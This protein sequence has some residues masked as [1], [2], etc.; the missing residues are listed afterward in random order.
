MIKVDLIMSSSFFDYESY[1]PHGMCY[2]WKGEILWTSVISDVTT[3]LAYY[4]ITIAFIVFVKKRKDLAY[5]WFFI[6]AGS[7]I[8]MACGTSHIISA[9]VVWEP[10]YG[11]SAV[12]KAITA[13][14]SLAAGVL[15]WYILPF[16]ISLPSPSMLE[17]IVKKRTEE[18]AKSNELLNEEIHLHKKSCVQLENLKNYMHNI[19]DSM[20]SILIG[21]DRN[22]LITQWN[23]VA[24]EATGLSSEEA[25]GM[26]LAEAFPRLSSDTDTVAT[27]IKTKQKQVDIKRAFMDSDNSRYEDITIYPLMSNGAE[28]AVIRID[29]VTEQVI[30]EEQINRTQ[31]MDVFGKLAGGVAHDFNNMLGIVIGYADLLNSKMRLEPKLNKYVDSIHKAAI[32]GTKLTNKLMSFSRT[33]SLESKKTNINSIIVEQLDMIQKALTV[34]INLVLA[35]DEKLWSTC[36]DQNELV[37]AVLN[38][39]INAMHAMSNKTSGAQLTITTKNQKLNEF[40]IVNIG[41]KNVGDYIVL[42]ITDNGEGMDNSAKEKLFDPF[43]STKGDKGTGLGLFQVFGFINRCGGIIKVYSEIDHGSKFSLYFPRSTKEGTGNTII[44]RE[45]DF[46]NFEQQTI[47]VVDDEEDLCDLMAEMLTEQGIKVLTTNNADDALTLLESE[48]VDLLISDIIMPGTDGYQL[49][50]IVSDKY[51]N[52][53][54]QLVSGFSDE[55]HQNLV[56][57]SIQENILSKPYN[58]DDLLRSI[59]RLLSS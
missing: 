42:S 28:G 25:T 48:N 56:D 10:I 6:L 20:P 39:C 17:D 19:I 31:K 37:D 24:C 35:L 7:I 43:F 21:V 12:A 4:S 50:S 53:K 5:P 26:N 46:S 36:I 34:R 29:D 45:I 44:S 15:I 32:R 11:I 57:K 22:N 52:I 8:F 9:I 38:I 13:V 58:T 47:L 30:M 3:A 59:Q 49:A 40:D 18:L 1:M 2:L 23:S 55:R 14:S 41:L 33:H 54:I 51:P 27:A 16:F